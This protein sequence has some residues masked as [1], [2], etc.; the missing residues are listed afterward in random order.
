MERNAPLSGDT[1]FQP[2][3]HGIMVTSQGKFSGS[4]RALVPKPLP[5]SC[6]YGFTYPSYLT[7]HEL[8]LTPCL[9]WAAS[10]QHVRKTSQAVKGTDSAARPQ[11][12]YSITVCP[13][14]S[15]F[16][17]PQFPICIMELLIVLTS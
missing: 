2:L 1:S 17:L 10:P 5:L 14:A 16:P 9:L 6:L 11:L 7:L 13:W 8:C 15:Y 12:Y 4:W 3:P